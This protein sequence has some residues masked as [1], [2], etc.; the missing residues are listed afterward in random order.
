MS[1]CNPVVI[2]GAVEGLLDEALVGY[3]IEHAG[4]SS[5]PIYGKQ[6]KGYLLRNLRGYN[7]SARFRPWIILIDLN[8]DDECAP[9]FRASLLPIPSTYMCFRIAVR[10]V[11]AWLFADRER[12]A[13]FLSIPVSRIPQNPEIIDQPKRRMVDIASSSRRRDIREDMVPRPGSGRII[14]PAYTSRLIE[15]VLDPQRG[16]RPDVA[17]QL[18]E[19]LAR[20]MRCLC[21]IVQEYRD[22]LSSS[23]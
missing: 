11:E 18:S 5:G 13:R 8:N 12:L 6:G 7:Q 21:R 16:W 3:L 19:S 9:P 2:S 10:E 22:N 17:V 4:A 15:F 14:G 20:C 23:S 1:K